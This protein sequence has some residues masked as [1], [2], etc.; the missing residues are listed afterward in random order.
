VQ[1]ATRREAECIVFELEA[2]GRTRDRHLTERATTLQDFVHGLN[3]RCR[4][5][6]NERGTLLIALELPSVLQPDGQ[7]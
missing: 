7:A 2:Q 6:T 1:V 5:D 3:G 4:F